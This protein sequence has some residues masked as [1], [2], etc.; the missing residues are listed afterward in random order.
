MIVG[1]YKTSLE[2]E[3][4]EVL[5]TDRGSEALELV[6]REKPEVVLLDIILPE[7][8]GFT[9]LKELKEDP[10]TKKIPVLMLTNLGQE[11]DQ[12]KGKT[13]GADG[14]FVKAQHTPNDIILKVKDLIK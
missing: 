5:T 2:K 3:G 4:F 7:I 6:K 11:S 14:Y 10:N 9:I 8:D 1:M 12:G 13:M